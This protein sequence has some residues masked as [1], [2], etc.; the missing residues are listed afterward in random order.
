MRVAL[1]GTRGCLG[2]AEAVVRR[3]ALEPSAVRAIERALIVIADHELNAS[4]FAARIAAS[5]GASRA[6]SLV[7]GLCAFSGP[8]HG[9]SSVELEALAATIGGPRRAR[10]YVRATLGVGHTIPGF[11]HALYPRGDVRSAP[12]VDDV[13]RILRHRRRRDAATLLAL[14]DAMR[15]AGTEHPRIDLAFVMLATALEAPRGTASWLFATG[16]AAGWLAH[17]REQASSGEVLR[18][19]ARYVP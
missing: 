16:R 8:R 3:L 12:V 18:P 19:R 13:R 9:T 11:A 6:A 4:T 7:A 2:F 14:C 17:A 5:T 10:D 15:D 1:G